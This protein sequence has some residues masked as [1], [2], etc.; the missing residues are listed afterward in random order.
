M[1]YLSI[2]L[3]LTGLTLLAAPVAHSKEA[4]P[5]EKDYKSATEK[6]KDAGKLLL[7]DFFHPK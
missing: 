3:M 5:W 4:I 2:L 6:A 1:R 7:I